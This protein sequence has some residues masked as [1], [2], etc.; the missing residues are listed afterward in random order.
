MK[1]VFEISNIGNRQESVVRQ[2][3]FAEAEKD[4]VVIRSA[5]TA[6][7]SINEHLMW[8]WGRLKH[9]RKYL[10][11]IQQDGAVLTCKIRGA[12]ANIEIFPNGA[13]MLHLLN[14]KLVIEK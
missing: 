5:L 10:K 8:L 14:A 4:F 7:A 1:A 6:D 3:P 11:G 2:V 9:E 13:E 12:N